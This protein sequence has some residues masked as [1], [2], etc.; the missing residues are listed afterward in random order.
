MELSHLF[1]F[2]IHVCNAGSDSTDERCSKL[3]CGLCSQKPKPKMDNGG[4]MFNNHNKKP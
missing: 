4:I 2:L 3:G 1:F